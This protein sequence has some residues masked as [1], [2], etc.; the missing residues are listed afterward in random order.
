MSVNGTSHLVTGSFDLSEIS[1]DETFILSALYS[2]I[3]RHVAE[4][5]AGDPLPLLLFKGLIL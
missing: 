5:L 4:I 2:K 1:S 3:T